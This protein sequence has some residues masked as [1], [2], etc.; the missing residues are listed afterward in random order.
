M[1]AQENTGDVGIE[2]A[3]FIKDNYLYMHPDVELK[4]SDDLLG[5][6][7]IDSLAFVELVEHV[8]TRFR[9]EVLDREITEDNFGSVDAISA[10]VR[11]K[12]AG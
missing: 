10:F 9:V 1:S 5:L 3:A 11:R 6:G 12:Q 7:L 2:V 4:H 8:Q